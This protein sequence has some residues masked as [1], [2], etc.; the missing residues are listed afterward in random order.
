MVIACESPRYRERRKEPG[1]LDE[2]IVEWSVNA[3]LVA[4]R[5][6]LVPWERDRRFH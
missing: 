3:H 5:F 6:R 4:T 2:K 1:S